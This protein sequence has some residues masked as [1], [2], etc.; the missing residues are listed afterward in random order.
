MNNKGF[1]LTE[2]I[3][4]LAIMG[5]ILG[6][7]F[8]AI[9][10]LQTKN[11]LQV[12][13]TYENVLITGSKLYVDKYDIDLFEKGIES[14]VKITYDDLRYE[15]FIKNFKSKKKE[16]VDSNNTFVYA[17][18]SSNGSVSYEVSL[19]TIRGNSIVYQ[20]PGVTVNNSCT[21]QVL[22]Q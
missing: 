16:V 21:H 18:K 17:S 10:N 5:V 11:Q 7:S 12:Y 3:V 20:T 15:E 14:C 2:L 8:P 19:R 13:K 9:T 6:L 1:T 22:G 4:T